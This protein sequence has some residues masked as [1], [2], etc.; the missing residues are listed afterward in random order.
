MEFG[1]ISPLAVPSLLVKDEMAHPA[2]EVS[3]WVVPIRGVPPFVAL[4]LAGGM[5]ESGSEFP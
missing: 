4:A 1:C 2:H 5:I 3:F